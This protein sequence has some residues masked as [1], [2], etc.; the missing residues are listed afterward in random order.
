MES[1]V[2][3]VAN[4]LV[5]VRNSLVDL[6]VQREAEITGILVGMLSREATILVGPPGTAKTKLLTTLAKLTNCNIFQIWLSPETDEDSLF[7]PLD[8]KAYR[9]GRL[10]RITKGFI[11]T[12]DIVLIHEVFRSNRGV[13]DALLSALEEKVVKIGGHM[14]QLPCL[15]FYFDTNFIST[16]EEDLAFWDRMTVRLFVK[17][18]S[19]D[20]WEELF[21]VAI[22]LEANNNLNPIMNRDDILLLQE[23]VRSRFLTLKNASTLIRK[24]ILVL[25]DL[26]QQG[27]EVSDRKKI[28]VLK[29][30]SALSIL[31][32][33]KSVSLDSLAD[34]LRLCI[35]NDEDEL[36]K[37]EDI[38]LKN[39]LS[40][41]YS[42]IQKL[43]TLHAELKNAI[44]KFMSKEKKTIED[45]EFLSSVRRNAIKELSRLPTN[46][47]LLP[48]VRPLLQAIDEAGKILENVKERILP[49]DI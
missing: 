33:E 7:G 37:I 14:V 19:S 40:S 16:D 24:Y 32:M 25:N 20:K 15:A 13:R 41:Y 42:Q 4:K 27:I 6:F 21:S 30:A 11:P 45:L 8:I 38:I 3:E 22:D 12:A 10:T 31:Y 36:E 29:I 34:A 28:K 18:V 26:M 46:P 48:Y 47:R 39:Q 49:N 23:V 2:N 9:E 43:Q 35:P 1:R 44:Q 17:Y 5:K